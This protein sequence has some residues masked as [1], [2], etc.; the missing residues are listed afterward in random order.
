MALKISDILKALNDEE[1]RY[2]IV[3]G[4]AVNLHGHVRFTKDLDLIFAFD[5]TNLKRRWRF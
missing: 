1:I 4:V 2:V 5:E 3:G